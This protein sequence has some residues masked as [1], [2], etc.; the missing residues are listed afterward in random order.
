MHIYAGSA[1]VVPSMALCGSL[2][3]ALTVIAVLTSAADSLPHKPLVSSL[4]VRSALGPLG[5]PSH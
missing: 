5:L 1:R 3:L 4:K 2:A